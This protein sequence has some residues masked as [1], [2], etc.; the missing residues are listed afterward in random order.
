VAAG[1]TPDQVPNLKLKWAF[2]FPHAA[3]MFGQPTIAAGRVFIGVDTGYVYSLDAAKGCVYWSYRAL[4]GVRNAITIAPVNGQRS[5]KYAAYFG[6]LRGNIYALN[7]ATGAL[8]W[9]VNVEDHPLAVITGAPTLHGGRLYVPVAS[10]EEAAGSDPNYPC[11]T[12]RGSIVAVDAGSGKRIWKT[13]TVEEEPKPTVKN[14]RGIQLWGP[15][16]VGVWASPTIDEKRGVMYVATGDAYSRPAPRTI[17]AVM[18]LDLA[19]GKIRWVVQHTEGDTWLVGCETESPSENCPDDLGPDY[20]FGSSSIMRTL[21]DG[22]TVLISG[23]KSGEVFAHDAGRDGAVI[24]KATLVEKLARGEIVFGGAADDQAAYFG[25]RSTGLVALDLATGAR[26]WVT[27]IPAPPAPRPSRGGPTAAL[28]VMPGVVFA[29]GWD[30]MLRAFAS[31]DGR[32][33]WHYDMMRDFTTVNGVAAKGGAMG[34]PGPVIAGGM[35]FAGSGYLGVGGGGTPGNVL[36]AFGA[37]E[38]PRP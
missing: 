14:S 4:S 36:L 17:D 10:R 24:W 37:D 23:Q 21:P 19:T 26:K 18:A 32:I 12:F 9:K 8:L 5:A 6:D 3:A 13:Y 27:T 11:C 35:L 28:S 25:V 29:G 38:G 20:D 1:L 2:G 16:G 33:L 15:S 7:A 30:G 31:G 34:G 22:R